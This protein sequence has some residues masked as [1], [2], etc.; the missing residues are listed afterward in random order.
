MEL[1]AIIAT[2]IL[3]STFLTMIFSFAAY[4]VTRAKA[5]MKNKARADLVREP[6]GDNSKRIFFV[7]YDPQH[8]EGSPARVAAAESTDQWR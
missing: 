3:L 5:S 4:I 8:P 7:R 1:V 2:I 6:D